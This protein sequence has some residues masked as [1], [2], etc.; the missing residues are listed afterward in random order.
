[1]LCSGISEVHTDA[2]IDE[3]NEIISSVVVEIHKGEILKKNQCS[4]C[5]KLFKPAYL[6]DHMFTHTGE[7]TYLCSVCEKLFTTVDA[8]RKHETVHTTRRP[9]SYPICEMS[10]KRSGHL[11]QHMSTHNE[12]SHA[13]T[14]CGKVFI[15][16]RYL[17][18]HMIS[19]ADVRPHPCELC[20]KSFITSQLTNH[21]RL[22]TGDKPFRCTI[23]EMSFSRIDSLQMH[24]FTH[25]R[26]AACV[27]YL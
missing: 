19:H 10:F 17:R 11:K 9:F 7:K 3:N 13:C 15:L 2:V 8:V 25:R 1:M 4:L 22:H 24:T 27:H 21:M 20:G 26:E 16:D 5:E 18:H 6:R 14:V 23:W 12:K